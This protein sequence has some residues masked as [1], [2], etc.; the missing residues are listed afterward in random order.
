MGR[1]RVVSC[2]TLIPGEGEKRFTPQSGN[3]A[4]P[5]RVLPR[6][7]RCW[8]RFG[9]RR[10]SPLWYSSSFETRE[11]ERENTKAAI[12]AA[13]QIARPILLGGSC[14]EDRSLDCTGA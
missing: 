11:K 6:E 14:H 3:T 5:A 12:L 2:C 13:L 7:A 8:L 1:L 9:V 10:E 4:R